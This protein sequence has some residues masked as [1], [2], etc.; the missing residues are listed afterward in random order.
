MTK[1]ALVVA[2]LTASFTYVLAADIVLSRSFP[3]KYCSI[4]I[5]R[6]LI[7]YCNRCILI[8]FLSYI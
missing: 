2:S 7:F 6:T 8:F 3:C 1:I 5:A 4:Y